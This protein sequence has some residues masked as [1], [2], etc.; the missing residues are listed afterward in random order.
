V[1]I[2][3]INNFID[4]Y[5]SSSFFLTTYTCSIGPNAPTPDSLYQQLMNNNATWTVIDRGEPESYFAIW[6]LID[7]MGQG[8][9]LI[10]QCQLLR[11]VWEEMALSNSPGGRKELLESLMKNSKKKQRM[12]NFVQHLIDCLVPN[13]HVGFDSD[14][15]EQF[16]TALK[17][18]VD[19]LK[20]GGEDA[21]E[22]FM[23]PSKLI[24]RGLEALVG[25]EPKFELVKDTTPYD[26]AV[27]IMLET[28]NTDWS[29]YF[30]YYSDTFTSQI[31]EKGERT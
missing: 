17:N 25:E 16:E 23:D 7:Y 28:K 2:Y 20:E 30:V 11:E 26:L 4:R 27:D 29:E 5:S 6:D 1:S 8:G 21:T 3:Q 31:L 12:Y 24:E 14:L 10:E 9:Q 13:N 15:A 18:G 19:I 22:I